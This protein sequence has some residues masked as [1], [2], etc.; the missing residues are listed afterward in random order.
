MKLYDYYRSSACYRVRI[1]LNIKQIA[2]E[3]ST[4]HL[5]EEGGQHHTQTYHSLNPQELVPTLEDE[6]QL[7]TQSLAIIDY[8]E[9]KIPYPSLFPTNPIAK[10][11]VKSLALMVACDMHPLNNLRVLKQLE[12]QFCATK[13]DINHWYHHW[14]QLGFDAIEHHLQRLPRT[15]SVCY[16]DHISLADVCLIPQVY[17]AKRFNFSLEAYPLIKEI[18]DYCLSLPSFLNATPKADSGDL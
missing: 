2:Y 6:Q 15:I 18:N 7:F 10:T 9:E 4:V 8:L 14:L 11:Q 12:Q 13:A 1:A 17:N 3:I 5:L 16:G